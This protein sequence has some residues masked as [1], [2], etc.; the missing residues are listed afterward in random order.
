M[1]SIFPMTASPFIATVGVH[2]LIGVVGNTSDEDG[3]GAMQFTF[4]PDTDF[5]A[6]GG[7]VVVVG[8]TAGI[9]TAI[10]NVAWMPIPYRK[11][12]INNVASDYRFATASIT[13]PSSILVPAAGMAI[14]LLFSVLGGTCTIARKIV[15]GPSAP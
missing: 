6:A 4:S 1:A 10:N 5:V 8:R 12:T 3:K 13:G 11:V 14:G 7:E 15:D 2:G 9:S